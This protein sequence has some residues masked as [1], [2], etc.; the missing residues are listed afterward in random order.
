MKSQRA[1]LLGSLITLMLVLMS[2]ER[3]SRMTSGQT[4]C[5]TTWYVYNRTWMACAMTLT[6]LTQYLHVMILQSV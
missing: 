6:C 1:S 2:L 4:L 5:S 3:L